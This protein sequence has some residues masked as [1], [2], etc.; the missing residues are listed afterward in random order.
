[1]VS[2]IYQTSFSAS[3][4]TFLNFPTGRMTIPCRSQI[5][6]GQT[7]SE[8]RVGIPSPGRSSASDRVVAWYFR[9]VSTEN[10]PS[11]MPRKR[12]TKRSEEHTSELQSHSDLVCR[13]L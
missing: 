8:R 11:T 1:M 13:L 6:N 2:D 12:F 7:I 4:A 9:G 3:V 10:F 5:V